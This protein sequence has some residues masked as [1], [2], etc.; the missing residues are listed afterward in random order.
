MEKAASDPDKDHGL[1]I[2]HLV[3]IPCLKNSEART[4]FQRIERNITVKGSNRLSKESKNFKCVCFPSHHATG[5]FFIRT[6]EVAS[7]WMMNRIQGIFFLNPQV[8]YCIR[9]KVRVLVY[10]FHLE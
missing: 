3:Q 2:L 9:Y 1:E 6:Q 5:L 4:L 8:N 10:F 7:H